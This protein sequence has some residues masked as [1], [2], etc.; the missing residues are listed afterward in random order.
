MLFGSSALGGTYGCDSATAASFLFCSSSARSIS[1]SARAASASASAAASFS[2]TAGGV[3]GS[4]TV[5]GSQ[6]T[7]FAVASPHSPCTTQAYSRLFGSMP[8]Q[9]G[10]ITVPPLASGS[11]PGGVH[12][13]TVLGSHSLICLPSP[14]M[15]GHWPCTSHR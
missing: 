9:S 4:G 10:F 14:S 8:S 3:H 5:L 2:S 7:T 6:P 1:P 11:T 13:G 15:C 12:T